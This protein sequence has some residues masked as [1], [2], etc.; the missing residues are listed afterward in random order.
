MKIDLN[1]ASFILGLL[2]ACSGW[3]VWWVN[4]LTY[5]KQLAN[6]DKLLSNQKAAEAATKAYA[7]ERDFN[8][9][10]NNLSQLQLGLNELIKQQDH[11]TDMLIK[12]M[13][14]IKAYLIA[15]DRYFRS[16]E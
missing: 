1:L 11:R 3:V 14:E 7:A 9:I 10:K 4:K 16:E 6:Q 2:S 15:K 8:H 12:E 13:V 5:D